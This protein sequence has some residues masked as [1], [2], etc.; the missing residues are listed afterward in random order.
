MTFEGEPTGTADAAKQGASS[1][2]NAAR[3]EGRNVASEA[4]TQAQQVTSTAREEAQHV[5][6][7]MRS[8]AGDVAG[9]V[10]E[11][12]RD[13]VHD[14]REEAKRRADEQGARAAQALHQTSGQL[15]SFGQN[16]EDGVLVDLAHQAAEKVDHL[17]S[18]LENGGVERVMRDVRSFAQRKPGTFLLAAGAAGFLLGRLARNASDLTGSTDAGASSTT[19]NANA[20]APMPQSPLPGM[21]AG[22]ED[23]VPYMGGAAPVSAYSE[24][25]R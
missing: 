21:N 11:R 2:A 23:D 5:T 1:V 18:E 3:D 15:R 10:K 24:G 9:E 4:K 17:A 25:L 12:A 8:Q 19:W 22:L 7:A 20:N 14:L 6:E 16:S 13:V